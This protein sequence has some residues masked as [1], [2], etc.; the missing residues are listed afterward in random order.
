[1]PSST[2]SELHQDALE[3]AFTRHDQ[4]YT[5]LALAVLLNRAGQ[6]LIGPELTDARHLRARGTE[7]ACRI[8]SI[9]V[10]VAGAGEVNGHGGGDVRLVADF[11]AISAG[12][13]PSRSVT[14]IRDSLTGHMIA[15][16]ADTAMREKRVVEIDA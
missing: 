10:N 11:A 9:D 3:F 8:E 4:R 6:V 14:H 1:M 2:S 13:T 12:G 5:H 7:Q 15:F 16:A